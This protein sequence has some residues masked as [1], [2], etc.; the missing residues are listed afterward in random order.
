[1]AKKES[2]LLIMFKMV[3]L[4]AI[5]LAALI[6]GFFYV[7]DKLNE[8][9]NRGETIEVPDFR[10]KHLVQ[11]IK[12]K[13]S[14]LNIEKRDEKFDARFPKDHVLAQF[15][16]PGTKVKPN[17]KVFL[18]ISL[19][20]KQVSVPDICQKN[21]RESVL[22]LINAQ[23]KEGNRAYLTSSKT[24][25]DKIMAQSPL[26]LSPHQVQAGVDM[27]ISLGSGDTRAP[28]PNF[29]GRSL[30]SLRESL[31]ALGL[32]EGRVVTKRDPEK[33]TSIIISTRPAPYESVPEGQAIDFL[34]SAGNAAGN[35]TNEDLKKFELSETTPP[36]APKPTTSPTSSG[37][38][39]SGTTKP[40]GSPPKIVID[41][42]EPDGDDD[43]DDDPEAPPTVTV[44]DGAAKKSSTPVQFVMPDGFMPKEVKFFLVSESGREQVYSGTHKPL[45][46]IKVN[47][48]KVPQGRVQIYINDVPIEERP[49][50]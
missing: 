49:L 16:E 36:P 37:S 15:P 14:E 26:P 32:K 2:C 20:S 31:S 41:G 35:A 47:V 23:L 46:V 44:D 34:V 13:P 30:L 11:V 9:F 19:G 43:D 33:A 1:M 25:R 12:E 17:K 45:D 3:L 22:L 24:T 48:P 6:G 4:L 21:L 27:L 28:L 50:Q 38:S 42:E 39:T 5:F 7:K 40:E 10:G 29:T 18:T 8:Y